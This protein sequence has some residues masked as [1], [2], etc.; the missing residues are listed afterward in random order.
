[1]N[2][3]IGV[4]IQTNKSDVIER[5]KKKIGKTLRWKQKNNK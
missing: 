5:K 4:V 3:V 1:M 2:C